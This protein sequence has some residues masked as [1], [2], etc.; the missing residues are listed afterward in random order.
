MSNRNAAATA[1]LLAALAV[2]GC[3]P[4]GGPIDFPVGMFGVTSTQAAMDLAKAGFDAFQPVGVSG[5]ENPFVQLA[6]REGF[7]LLV[8]PAWKPDDKPGCPAFG[9]VAWYLYDEPDVHGVSR[10]EMIERHREARL[11]CPNDPTALVVGDGRRARD[12]SGI[13]EILMVDWY[14]VPHLPLESAGDHVR[15]TARAAQGARTWAVLQAMDWRDF[16]QRDPSKPK[17]GRFPTLEEIRFMSYDAVLNGARGV[18]YFAYSSGHGRD[19]GQAPG[20]LRAVEWV[21]RELRSMAPVFGRGREVRLPFDLASGAGYAARCWTFAGRDYLV[22]A[23]RGSRPS[24]AL[25]PAVL[26]PGWRPLFEVRRDVRDLLDERSDGYHLRPYQVLVLESRLK[27]WRVL[28]ST[29]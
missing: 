1:L 29:S 24:E 28:G 18:W 16:P 14:P 22:L 20:Q 11:R 6:R 3:S 2:G 7:L 25:P 5:P 8:P 23:R 27:V 26:A 13:S 9:N 4:G 10:A 21:A 17:V 15:L 19:L 12:Y